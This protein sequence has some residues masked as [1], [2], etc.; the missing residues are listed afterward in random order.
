MPPEHSRT[1]HC[2]QEHYGTMSDVG[3]TPEDKVVQ[4]VVGAGENGIGGDST[5]IQE[6]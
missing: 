3:E 2:D 6:A 4:A 5:T 1:V